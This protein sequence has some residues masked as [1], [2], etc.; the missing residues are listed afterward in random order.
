[1]TQETRS[2]YT[3]DGAPVPATAVLS[4]A[5]VSMTAPAIAE[6]M[7]PEAAA[8]RQ[9]THC[10][11][12]T[13]DPDIVF[14]DQ[15]VCNHCYLYAEV[16]GSRLF[17]APEDRHRLE[18]LLADIRRRGKGK[19]YDCIIGVSGG[20]DS[21]YVAYLTKR[22]GLRPLAV[23]LDNGWDSELAV[24][25]IESILK[26]L[27]ID[28]YT[29]VI[30]WVEFK[31][32]QLSFLKAS[33]PDAEVPTDHAIM[34]I[35]YRMAAKHGV[36]YILLGTN[37]ISESILPI[38]WGYGYTDWRYIRNVQRKFGTK[39]LVSFPRFGLFRWFYYAVV[40][41]IQVVSILNYVEYDKPKAMQTIQKEL[42][43]IDYGGKHYES[44][45]TRFFQAYILPR[46]FNIDKRK[47]HYSNLICS[48]Q[49]TRAKALEM[50]K[51]PVCPSQ[52]LT[53]DREYTIKKLGL[54][55]AGFEEIMRLPAK[56][57]LDYPTQYALTRRL[58][59]VKW[60]KAFLTGK[61]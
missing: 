38:K 61:R 5:A 27:D 6:L 51:N 32:L 10:I 25:N 57:F 37:V 8:Y 49:L 42:G 36:P 11:M 44:I 43:W 7:E 40:R 28:L 19:E 33:T 35:L 60:L 52:M 46:K 58:K 22:F 47:A 30:D 15:G 9:C 14:D 31:D 26:K 34:A 4:G 17:S 59:K 54:T 20:V 39:K 24:G 48:G 16:S 3:K 55:D 18:S 53:E 29:Y 23:H 13:T 45:Y 1:V 50:M 2:P 21:T 56:T 12:D 41:R